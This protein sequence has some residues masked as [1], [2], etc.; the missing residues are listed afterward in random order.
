MMTDLQQLT[1]KKVCVKNR[2]S[3]PT[4]ANSD[5]RSSYGKFTGILPACKHHEICF[6]CIW[7]N[8]LIPLQLELKESGRTHLPKRY[9]NILCSQSGVSLYSTITFQAS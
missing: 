1:K 9:D 4:V 6:D 7:K 3:L 5:F 8:K 2:H